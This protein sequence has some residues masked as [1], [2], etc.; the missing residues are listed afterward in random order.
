M[1]DSLSQAILLLLARQ[2]GSLTS[3]VVTAPGEPVD[4]AAESI[5]PR[6]FSASNHPHPPRHH[7]DS[8]T[9]S[10]SSPSSSQSQCETHPKG[11]QILF[12]S[13][14]GLALFSS[15]FHEEIGHTAKA[16]QD[17]LADVH[18]FSKS[19]SLVSFLP[20]ADAAQAL[21]VANEI[22]EGA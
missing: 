11:V 5:E 8:C 15:S 4:L 12:E 20:F 13:A 10:L 22:S 18:K 21:E 1:L 2:R 16:V 3:S 7:G 6:H 17:A 9:C 14:T 19:V